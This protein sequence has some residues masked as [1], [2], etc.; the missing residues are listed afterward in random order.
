[1]E[2]YAHDLCLCGYSRYKHSRW[3]SD[4]DKLLVLG[5]H[6]KLGLGLTFYPQRERDDPP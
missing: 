6:A 4:H 2:E 5:E 3:A 1:M